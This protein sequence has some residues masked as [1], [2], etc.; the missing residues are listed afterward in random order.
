VKNDLAQIFS[1]WLAG[2][3]AQAAFNDFELMGKQLFVP[4]A[5]SH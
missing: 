4:N 3:E 1:K 5:N 2:A